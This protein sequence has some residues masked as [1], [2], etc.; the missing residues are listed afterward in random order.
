MG[1]FPRGFSAS[2][3]I[4][5]V[6]VLQS[7]TSIS[8]G[9]MLS[10]LAVCV[11][12]VSSAFAESPDAL[13]KSARAVLDRH[14]MACHGEAQMAELDMRERDTLL[15]GGK[16]GPAVVPGKAE[17]SLLYRAASHAGELKMPPGAARIPK[18][19]LEALRDWINEE[20]WWRPP[21][22][23][24]IFTE[25]QRSF[26][27]FQPIRDPKPPEVKDTEWAKTP[28]D[29][30]ILAKLEEKGLSPSPPADKRTLIRRATYDLTG[31]PPALEEIDEFLADEPEPDEY[32]EKKPFP[33]FSRLVDRLLESPRYG[34][35]W[36]RHWLDVVRYADSTAHDGNFIMRYAYR[37]RD[38]VVRA[39]NDDKPYDQFIIEQLAGDLLPPTKNLDLSLQRV[40]ATGFLMLGPKALGEQDKE[41]VRMDIVDE[42]IDVTGKVFLGLTVACARCHDHKFDPIPTRDYYSMAGIFRSTDVLADSIHTSMWWEH[43]VLEIPGGEKVMVM[44]PKEGKL[45]D[46]K[47]HVRGNHNNLGE[48][49]PRG[50]LQIIA[51]E[52]RSSIKTKQSGRLELAR[53]IASPDNPLTARVMVNRIW[54]GHFGTGLV[55]SSDNFGSTG[56]KPSHPELLDWLAS[57]FIESG[58]SI[59]SVHRLILLSN[60]YRMQ[61]FPREKGD[62]V[63]PDN[64][65]IW[66][67]N[68][69]RLDTEQLR[70]SV[71]AISGRLDRAIGGDIWDWQDK[72][73]TVDTER[74]LFSAAKA[75]EGFEAYNSPRRSLYVPVVRNQLPGMFQQFDFADANAVTSKR[76]DTTVA[77]QALFLMNNPFAREQSLHFATRLL[78][79]ML[80][81]PL[82]ERLYRLGLAEEND[83]GRLRL[84]HVEVLGR[85]PTAE[86]LAQAANFLS[87]YTERLK[88]AGQSA[89]D[90]RLAAWQSYCQSL[91]S[92][93]EFLYVN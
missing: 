22:Q 45:A 11:A 93:N 1:E 64:R 54:Q 33:A 36:A 13:E 57:R 3:W 90:S 77:P 17:T 70:D 39:L 18:G 16:S 88:S 5:E 76:N 50:V 55:A 67:A 52:G 20:A 66:R 27:S 19:D 81:Q 56:E 83:E 73:E 41:Q 61:S 60:T 2:L 75:G 48:E 78:E 91:F 65:L 40:I 58:W 8:T 10:F 47:I 30:F 84:A 51:G 89:D 62:Q 86:E 63:D 14:C 74:G 38:Y 46:L 6:V 68:R 59:K 26:W 71:L 37:Y 25:E 28:L 87:E 80:E 53:W 15:K 34:E 44:A 23:E 21:E 79:G 82:F 42:Q 7:D 69:R 49:A 9:R 12:G 92:L 85:P 4:A 43:D 29:R 32:D 35:R 72:N 24:S 31:L